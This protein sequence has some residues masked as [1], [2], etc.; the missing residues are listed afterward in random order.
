MY[1]K[2]RTVVVRAFA[3]WWGK[4]SGPVLHNVQRV[5]GGWRGEAAF[6]YAGWGP[7]EGIKKTCR[8]AGVG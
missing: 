4:G 6:G 5:A 1:R 2:A 8:A 3:F 7:V